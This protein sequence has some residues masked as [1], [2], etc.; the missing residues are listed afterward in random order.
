M[1]G[2]YYFNSTFIYKQTRCSTNT[3]NNI[4]HYYKTISIQIASLDKISPHKTLWC[5]KNGG[6]FKKSK[7][8]ELLLFQV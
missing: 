4:D 6:S 5:G 1:S 8:E 7:R 3:I 2:Q